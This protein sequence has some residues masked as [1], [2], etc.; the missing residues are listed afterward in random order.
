MN[1]PVIFS[2]L[3]ITKTNYKKIPI[4]IPI[5]EKIILEDFSGFY[6]F[7]YD[8]IIKFTKNKK[9]IK[10]NF[11]IIINQIYGLD[12]IC[13]IKMYNFDERKYQWCKNFKKSYE[14]SCY[15]ADFL[16][17]SKMNLGD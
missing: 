1:K 5:I 15:C 11:C 10:A 9:K 2:S 8:L 12:E 17:L 16:D 14:F 13:D 4:K 3:Y 6:G 7:N